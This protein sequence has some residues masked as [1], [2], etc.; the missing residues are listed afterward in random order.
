MRGGRQKAFRSPAVVPFMFS[1]PEAWIALRRWAPIPGKG[2]A[3]GSDL[4]QPSALW[5]GLETLCLFS[6]LKGSVGE[7]ESACV[8]LE[9]VNCREDG[10]DRNQDGRTA[11]FL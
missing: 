3:L 6:S 10:T 7:P 8:G 2:V 11:R 9:W 4:P 5:W 1:P